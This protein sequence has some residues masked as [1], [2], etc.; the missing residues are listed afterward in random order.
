[1]KLISMTDF[2]LE[3]GNP[4]NTDSQFADKVMAY[5]NFLKQ[6][7]KLEMFVCL[8]NKPTVDA[9]M[10]PRE[11]TTQY[12]EWFNNYG[13]HRLF[14]GFVLIHKSEKFNQTLI[15]KDYKGSYQI[16]IESLTVE[17]LINLNI[18]LSKNGVKQVFGKTCL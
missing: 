7:L 13:K 17:D 3:Q 4:S 2:V 15:A 18:K 10:Q 8:K 12:D 6:P 14:K 5:A 11:M 16:N 9:Y 1:M